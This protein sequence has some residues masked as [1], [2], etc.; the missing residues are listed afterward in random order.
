MS[1]SDPNSKIDLLDDAKAIQKK[2][3]KAFALPKISEDNGLIAFV[4]H[5]LLPASK[6]KHGKSEFIVERTRDGLEPLVY[7]SPEQIVK[8]YEADTL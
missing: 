5:V 4:E 6:I 8:D 2:I 3:S 7:S 1:A